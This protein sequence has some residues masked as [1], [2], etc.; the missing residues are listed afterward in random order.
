MVAHE[1]RRRGRVPA[2]RSRRRSRRAARSSGGPAAAAGWCA[3]GP[4]RWSGAPRSGFRR[5]RPAACCASPWRRQGAGCCPR[6]RSRASRR[7]PA[8][9]GQQPRI[10]SMSART[11]WIAASRASSG[12]MAMRASS[13]CAGLAS[14]PRK[15]TSAR[16]CTGR[17]P[18]K[19]PRPTWRQIRPSASSTA[20]PLRR[21]A[22]E[23]PSSPAELALR[24]QPVVVDEATVGDVAPDALRE[25]GGRQ[26]RSAPW[27]PSAFPTIGNGCSLD[28]LA[29]SPRTVRGGRS[30]DQLRHWFRPDAAFGAITTEDGGST[31][32]ERRGGRHAPGHD[33]CCRGAG[34]RRHPRR[35]RGRRA[36]RG[37]GGRG[38]PRRRRP[39]AERRSRGADRLRPGRR[40]GGAEGRRKRRASAIPAERV[41]LLA[42]LPRPA[43]TCSASAATMPTISPRAPAPRT[44]GSTSPRCRCSSPSRRPR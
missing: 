27:V 26:L 14:L 2:P 29:A 20:S 1:L 43:R 39:G 3:A 35:R 17:A 4:R 18:M 40:R 10:A 44:C 41:R 37:G 32:A 11:A 38:G 21:S 34:R 28:A 42:P 22:R 33:R 16:L 13:T 8:P 9:G 6:P 23:T 7:P 15:A 24:R 12:S 36:R 19:V 5:G 30:E 31:A 25:P